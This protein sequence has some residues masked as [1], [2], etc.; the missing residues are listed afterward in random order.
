MH[1]PQTPHA[2][3]CAEPVRHIEYAGALLRSDLERVQSVLART[4]PAWPGPDGAC[5]AAGE[6]WV[7]RLIELS[8]QLRPTERATV[9]VAGLSP[10]GAF[11]AW[12]TITLDEFLAR[13]QS[14]WFPQ[15]L[16]RGLLTMHFQPIIDLAT[17]ETFA[18]EALTRA[19]LGDRTF[20]AGEVI[21]AAR[22]HQAIFQFDQVARREAILQGS[23]GLRTGER[24]FINFMPQVIYDPE[25]CLARTWAAARQVGCSLSAL[26]FEV[27]E[28]EDFPD[29]DHLRTILNAY[30]DRGAEVALDDVGTGKTAL[31]YIDELRPNYIK[32]ARDLLPLRPSPKDLSIV[33]GIVDHAHHRG[34]TVLMEGLETEEQLLAAQTLGAEL[35]QGYYFGKP[36]REMAR[37]AVCRVA[38]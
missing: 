24:L 30:R 1:R 4:L 5:V 31:S 19:A 7:D 15:V 32:M 29:L 6:G 16:N 38:A 23:P 33:A 22:G 36:A 35:G 27:V 17:G 3:S 34:I 28:T 2:C 18:F 12:T 25:V 8:R 9:R 26:V 14:P 10:G 37:P 21:A 11:S 20:S 13:I